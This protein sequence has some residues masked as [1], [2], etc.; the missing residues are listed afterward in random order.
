MQYNCIKLTP[1]ENGFKFSHNE[2]YRHNFS[3]FFSLWNQLYQNPMT[4]Q[5]ILSVITH[6]YCIQLL[7]IKDFYIPNAYI[8]SLSSKASI[9][10]LFSSFYYYDLLVSYL[11]ILC[12]CHFHLKTKVL[13][14][15]HAYVW[16]SLFYTLYSLR[17]WS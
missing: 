12:L 13:S 17:T 14:L 3:Q 7:F 11:I 10:C 16:F 2:N 4:L 15:S 5:V 6:K 1:Y 9:H 8:Y